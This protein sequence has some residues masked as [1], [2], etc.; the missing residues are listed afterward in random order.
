MKC[1]ENVFGKTVKGKGK[2]PTTLFKKQSVFWK[3]EYWKEHEVRHCL[4]VMHIEKN[5]CDAVVGTLMNIHGKSKD[6]KAA[7]YDL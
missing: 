5:V 7:R 1:I 2:D 4:D 3:L 6:G